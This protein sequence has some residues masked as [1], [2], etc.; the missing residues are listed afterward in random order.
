MRLLLPPSGL[1]TILSG[2]LCTP[3]LVISIPA[4]SLAWLLPINIGLAPTTHLS[5]KDRACLKPPTVSV[6][7]EGASVV[8]P[9]V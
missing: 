5:A 1:V 2:S 3:V 6:Y 8:P 4:V 7:P 9:L